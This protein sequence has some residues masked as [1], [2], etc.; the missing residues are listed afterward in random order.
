MEAE[1][2]ANVIR[3]GD[4]VAIREARLDLVAIQKKASRGTQSR[5]RMGKG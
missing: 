5:C 3:L 4:P 1:S 2:D